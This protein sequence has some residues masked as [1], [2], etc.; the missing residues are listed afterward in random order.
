MNQRRWPGSSAQVVQPAR[1]RSGTES[2]VFDSRHPHRSQTILRLA[3]KGPY[4]GL[5][6]TL[7]M[8]GMAESLVSM[9]IVVVA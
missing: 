2:R 3:E 8:Y 6:G 1:N 5:P 9:W 7:T 4:A